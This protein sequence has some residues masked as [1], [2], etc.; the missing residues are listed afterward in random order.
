M[1]AKTTIHKRAR[2]NPGVSLHHSHMVT[3]TGGLSVKL[4]EHFGIITGVPDGYDDA[5][6]QKLR[7]MTPKEVVDRACEIAE[8]MTDK[9]IENQDLVNLGE[10]PADKATDE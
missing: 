5:G 7:L 9:L 4:A 3:F 1:T 6:R 8:L 10:P 2:Y